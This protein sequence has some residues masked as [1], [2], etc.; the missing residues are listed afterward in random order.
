M[1]VRFRFDVTKSCALINRIEEVDNYERH[2]K[3][4]NRFASG[5]SVGAGSR[6]D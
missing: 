4:P 3:W 6:P 1:T 2:V 5:S